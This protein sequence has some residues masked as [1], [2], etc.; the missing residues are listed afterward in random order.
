MA[1]VG[2]GLAGCA[3][4][5]ALA[6][7]G[8]RSLVIE[9]GAA[10]AEEGSG[11]AAGLFH[12][13]VHPGD[14]RHARFHRAAALAAGA[15]VRAAFLRDGVRGSAAGLLR[16]ETGRDLAGMQRLIDALGL[17]ADYLEALDRDAASRLAGARLSFPAWHFPGAGWVDPRAL[18]CSWLSDAGA[19]VRLRFGCTAMSMHRI[20]ADWALPD[21]AGATIATAPVVVLCNGDGALAGLSPWPIRRQ[22][23][24]ISAVAANEL[25]PNQTV[26]S[27]AGTT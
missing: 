6:E 26:P 20:D 18:A 13:V 19:S 4:A 27:I 5:R 14:G 8:V 25:A 22:R 10:V 12:G 21:P 24:Q 11:N 2:A 1:I 9:R 16:I 23:G 17:P 15:A 7:R 3:L